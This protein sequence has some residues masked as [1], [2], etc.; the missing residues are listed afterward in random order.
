MDNAL[1]VRVFEPLKNFDGDFDITNRSGKIIIRGQG[2]RRT[3]LNGQGVDRLLD[4]RTKSCSPDVMKPC[5]HAS[6]SS[7]SE[8]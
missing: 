6:A 3:V 2:A 8:V 7:R 4:T 5:R 1:A